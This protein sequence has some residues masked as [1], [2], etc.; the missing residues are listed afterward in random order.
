MLKVGDR[1]KLKEEVFR[2][3]HEN[4]ENYLG[5]EL[6][7]REGKIIDIQ[8]GGWSCTIEWDNWGGGHSG[9]KGTHHRD[10]WYVATGDLNLISSCPYDKAFTVTIEGLYRHYK[11]KK[12]Y[13]VLFTSTHS[14]TGEHLVSYAEQSNSN[15]G[16]YYGEYLQVWT[17]PKEMFESFVVNEDG[18]KVHRF[19]EVKIG[20]CQCCDEQFYSDE[21]V[22]G[23]YCKDCIVECDGCGCEVIKEELTE[24]MCEDCYDDYLEDRRW[25]EEEEDDE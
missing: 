1:V 19:Q 23:A 13:K 20:F 16:R 10:C 4:F 25:D 17:R 2:K 18:E 12:I 11:N 14:E 22:D 8:N 5:T 24:G 21:L 7:G 15:R 9:G 3:G 6:E